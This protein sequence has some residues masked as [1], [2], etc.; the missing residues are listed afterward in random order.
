MSFKNFR[1]D[2]SITQTKMA[3]IISTTGFK[4]TQRTISAIEVGLYNPTF[5]F[6][7]AFKLC[8]PKVLIDDIILEMMLALIPKEY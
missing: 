3:E 5:E 1:L 4:C 2:N 8:F 6:M 7:K